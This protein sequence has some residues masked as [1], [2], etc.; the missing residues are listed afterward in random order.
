MLVYPL[1]SSVQF[2]RLACG[3]D[4]EAKPQAAQAR[5]AFLSAYHWNSLA[6]PP[7]ANKVPSLGDGFFGGAPVWIL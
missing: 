6:Q 2:L 4:D 5:H 7:R 3:Y 1:L